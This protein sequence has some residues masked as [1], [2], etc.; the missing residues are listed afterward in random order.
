M[1]LESRHRFFCFKLFIYF[2]SLHVLPGSET[3]TTAVW[4][5]EQLPL[6]PLAASLMDVSLSPPNLILCSDGQQSVFVFALAV[7]VSWE[8]VKSQRDGD[9]TGENNI[10]LSNLFSPRL[11]NF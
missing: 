5:S 1:T 2:L 3:N 10:Q 4:P 9:Y 6:L 8:A 7:I 11:M